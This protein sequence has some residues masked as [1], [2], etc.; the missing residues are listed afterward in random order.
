MAKKIKLYS[1]LPKNEKKHINSLIESAELKV[2]NVYSNAYS[3]GVIMNSDEDELL[4]VFDI[5]KKYTEINSE[6]ELLMAPDSAKEHTE[7]NQDDN[8]YESI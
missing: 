7:M 8:D 2:I 1:K 5:V 6:E 3:K 4:I